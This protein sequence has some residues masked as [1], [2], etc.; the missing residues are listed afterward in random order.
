MGITRRPIYTLDGTPPRAAAAGCCGC[1]GT[2]RDRG[3]LGTYRD[4]GR[5]DRRR[6]LL[7]GVAPHRQQRSRGAIRGSCRDRCRMTQWQTAAGSASHR[8]EVMGCPT[9]HGVSNGGGGAM[10]AW[11][12]AQRPLSPAGG[13]PSRRMAQRASG[14]GSWDGAPA[15]GCWCRAQAGVLL[16]LVLHGCVPRGS[17]HGVSSRSWGFH[18]G[19]WSFALVTRHS[20]APAAR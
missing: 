2:Y 14:A 16:S 20:G 1:L 17:L 6:W 11:P 9:G 18:M 3:C 15:R 19:G 8:P 13:V 12:R 5:L 7:A 10:R 4:R